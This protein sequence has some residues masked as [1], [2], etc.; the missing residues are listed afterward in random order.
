MI[1]SMAVTSQNAGGGLPDP[2]CVCCRCNR[3]G[4]CRNCACC[5]ERRRCVSCLPG[6]LGRCENYGVSSG[7]GEKSV[8]E[9]EDN[10]PGTLDGN[11][12]INDAIP[13]SNV[14]M[15]D[16]LS[17][18]WTRFPSFDVLCAQNFIWGDVPGETFTHSVTCCYDEVVHWRKFLFKIPLAKCGRAFVI[19][20]TR[21][22]RA[23]ATGSALEC[24]ALK[25]AMI[26]PILL[27][28]R[29][30]VKS[31]DSDHVKLLTRHLS[32]WNRGD[33]DSLVS[34]GRTLQHQFSKSA[35]HKSVSD[36]ASVARRFSQLMMS[37]KVKDA[38]RL[39]SSVSDGGV[40]SLDSTVMDSLIRKHPKKRPPVSS[41][42]ID[43]LANPPHFILFDRLD[44][45][46]LR[47]VAL[48][49]HGAAGPLGL[50]ASAWRRM[51]TSFQTASDDLCDA[52]SAVARRLCTSFVDPAGL[53]SFVACRLIALD[54][55]P[56]VT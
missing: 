35:K 14:G 19:E 27:L 8:D 50:D 52:L 28:Q 44:A 9:H 37:G 15:A 16:D 7:P 26:M 49:L 2:S 5:K 21:L 34:E 38:L 53:S 22:F 51:C 6:R 12:L 33:I 32:L 45:V 23:Y 17:S 47:R 48:K 55:N 39:L 11:V 3:N 30:Y 13:D 24:V 42:L 20:Q 41:A 43:D 25:A 1:G 4:R 46:H 18:S 36:D 54:K 29:P 40:L 56:G 31:K 10:L